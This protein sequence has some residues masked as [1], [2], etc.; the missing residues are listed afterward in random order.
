[1]ILQVGSFNA[2]LVAVAHS[3][4]TGAIRR[5]LIIYACANFIFH[6][7]ITLVGIETANKFLLSFELLVLFISPA[8][9]LVFFINIW[10]YARHRQI[11]DLV[12]L[13]S[14]ALLFVANSAYY[15]YL[16]LG[17]TQRLWERGIWFSDNDVLHVLV[18]VWVIYVGTVLVKRVSDCPSIC[19]LSRIKDADLIFI[20]A[21]RR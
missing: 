3:S 12:L 8:I 6:F 19:P 17:Y 1:M 5:G 7:V 14:W 11:L 4:T 2:M 18:A 10:R 15:A 21:D 20:C 16:S 13:G 9:L